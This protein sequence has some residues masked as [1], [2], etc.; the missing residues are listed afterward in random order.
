[1]M[2][3]IL[4]TVF[5]LSLITAAIAQEH[6]FPFGKVTYREL[7]T[8]Y[9]LDT[10][11]AALVI[12]EFGESYID[13]SNNNN[14]L[15]E[16]HV[17]IK[18]LTKAGLKYADVEI[19]LYKS[20]SKFETVR[21]VEASSFT[22]DGGSMRETKL[23][24]KN[25]FT[26]NSTKFWDVKKFAIPNVRVGSIIEFRYTLE[27]PYIFNWRSWEFQSEIP[28]KHSEYWATI[29]GNYH[30]N[31]SL[32]GFQKLSKNESELVR[33]CFTPG[34]GNKADC[35]RYKWGMNDIPAFLEEDYMTAKKNFLSCINFELSEIEYFDGRKDKITK[36]WKDAEQELKRDEKFG[37]QI[38]KGKDIM[39]SHVDVLT[40][41]ETDPLQK[42]QRI[43]NFIKDWYRWD[44]NFGFTSE[45]G[46]RKAFDKKLGN[47]GDINLSLIAALKYAELDA[48]PLILSTRS[49]GFPTDLHPVLSDFNYVV[50]KLNINDKVYLLDAVDDFL[51]FGL[52]AERC[53]SGRG[54][55]F[56]EKESYW[57]DLKP[58]DKARQLSFIA[59][60]LD[61]AGAF[62]GTMQF[63]FAGYEGVRERKKLSSYSSEKDYINALNE[64]LR[65]VEINNYTI[66]NADDLKKSLVVKLNVAIEGYEDMSASHFLLNPF[67]FDRWKENP[68]KSSERLYPVD[69][70][71]PLEEVVVF[72]L[73]YPE[74]FAVTDLPEKV[75][76]ALPNAGGRYIFDIQNTGNKVSLNS[77]LLIAR[78]IYTSEE[79]HFLKELFSRVV[80]TQ[81]TDL[82]FKRK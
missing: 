42:A 37:I 13:N 39:D 69:F 22:I 76:L 11:T 51:P 56:G 72:S 62:T 43:Y 81:Q 18:I 7:D 45:F 59:L 48:E 53:L 67:M 61:K 70:G 33:E 25:I 8:K 31:I 79:Y 1:M 10:A 9:E 17:K 27:S 74:E 4:L 29:P 52:I 6:G 68:F 30:Y 41:G 50:A 46:I 73:E 64:K 36:E 34:G 16:Y 35:G 40:A 26:E 57:Y 2:R 63:T 15:L 71:P 3:I 78:T 28:K 19:P 21:D 47:V 66:E 60:K 58:A 49:N 5:C 77:S 55:V 75:G 54:R 38:R 80:S 20:N 24:Q 23:D 32:K 14:L 82:V 44:E 65:S 12:D